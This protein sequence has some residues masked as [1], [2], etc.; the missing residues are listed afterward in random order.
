[1]NTLKAM[2]R[3][4]LGLDLYLWVAYRTF[5]LQRPMR[6]S[7]PRLYR[8]FGVDPSKATDRVTVEISIK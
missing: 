5:T 8:Q 2:S 3:S 1:M 7:W 6:L 4:S